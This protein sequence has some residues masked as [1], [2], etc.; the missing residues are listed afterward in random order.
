MKTLRLAL[1][2]LFLV[3]PKIV[4]GVDGFGEF[5]SPV[6]NPIQFEDPRATTEVR[7]IFMYHRIADE[8]V[9]TGGNIYAI[10]LQLRLAL[11]ER[12]ALM[13]NKLGYTWL[14]PDREV[15]G[16]YE[17]GGGWSNLA[18]G[19]KYAIF[20]D[21][22]N[23]A[24]GTIGLRY[25]APSGE[26][27]GL[28]GRVFK[29][30]GADRRGGGLVNPFLSG[31]WGTG[32]LH[33]MGSTGWRIPTDSV[34]STFFDFSVHADYRVATPIGPVYPLVELN[35][36][37]VLDGGGRTRAKAEGFDFFNLG[38]GDGGG[39]GVV[40]LAAGARWRLLD[41]LQVGGGRS[42]AIDLG[43]A[44]EWAASGQPDIFDWRITSDLIFHIL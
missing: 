12:F 2:G 6:T 42:M 13:I 32:N 17:N 28:Q 37:Q 34:D 30:S 3:L 10:Q 4:L 20:R 40:T 26:S 15:Q 22:A 21:V 39:R 7:P 19:M 1:L 44:Y 9:T 36:V 16:F 41:Q 31:M 43:S 29:A 18:F 38:S 11:S 24:M 23:N 14:D 8:F 35:W 27:G 5:I 25:E 33:L